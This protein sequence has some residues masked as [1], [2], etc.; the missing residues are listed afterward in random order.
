M[1]QDVTQNESG[2]KAE[3][4]AKV[5][6]HAGIC[7]R[8]DA[9]GL[10]AQGRVRLNGKVLDTPATLVSDADHIEVDGAPLPR[11]NA[12]RLF[13]Y[14]KPTGLVTTHKDERGR[15][16]VFDALPKDL[17]RLVSVG[18]L[19]L[20][21]EGLL[22]LTTD[23]ELARYLEL[24][25]TGWSRNYRVRVFGALD[26]KKL[27]SLKNG[28]EVEGVKYGPIIVK[29]EKSAPTNS[30]LLVS[31]KEGKNREVRKVLGA[32]G[33]EV[34]RLLRVSYG[35]FQLG[36]LPRGNIREVHTKTLKEQIPGFFKK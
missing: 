2:E 9:E 1:S 7:S 36:Q 15:K 33:L 17:P 21:S 20:N 13:M 34:S 14:H 24:P 16:T 28:I 5:I 8:R 31:L 12:T 11:K 25:A 23:G 30:W 3:R 29:V 26:Q 22:L 10:I 6:A 18:R 35:P 27:D 19:D 32:L 4:I